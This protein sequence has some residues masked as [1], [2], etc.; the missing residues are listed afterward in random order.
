[1]RPITPDMI[2]QSMVNMT[3][4]D[5]RLMTLP[6]LHETVW[7]EREF[8]GWRDVH[9]STKGYLVFWAG[10]ELLGLMVR[11]AQSPMPAGQSAIC[12]LCHTQQP[13]PQVS[14]F[15][16]PKTGDE[17]IRGN[18]VGTYLCADLACS[19]LI[20]IQPAES[21]NLP[22]PE[23]LVRKKSLGLRDRLENFSRRVRCLDAA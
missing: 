2:S 8:L 1:M 10:D 7:D 18:T 6:G 13:A 12:A 15:T 16:A 23:R 20:R 19:L 4:A 5:L 14:L 22:R 17:G 3:E 11:A 9:H 21:E